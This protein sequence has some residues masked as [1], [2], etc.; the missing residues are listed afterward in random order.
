MGEGNS[1]SLIVAVKTSELQVIDDSLDEIEQHRTVEVKAT[2]GCK[3]RDFYEPEP[4]LASD[5]H[6]PMWYMVWCG[7]LPVDGQCLASLGGWLLT[8]FDVDLFAC[9]H[10]HAISWHG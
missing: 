4:I 6:I 2:W 3:D 10:C 5:T 7:S 1:R 8:S 9:V